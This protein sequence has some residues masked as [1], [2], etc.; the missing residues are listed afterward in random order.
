MIHGGQLK[1]GIVDCD[2]D[3]RIAMAFTIAGAVAQSAV[4]ILGC[5]TVST[6]FPNFIQ[7]AK[8]IGLDIREY[9][10]ERV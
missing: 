7:M 8:Q 4:T 3:H 5:E 2:L 9:N 10:N 1:G 6:S